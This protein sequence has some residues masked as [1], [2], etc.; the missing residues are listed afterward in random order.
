MTGRENKRDEKRMQEKVESKGKVQK[1][2]RKE[3]IVGR[4]MKKLKKQLLK[5]DWQC[6]YTNS[7]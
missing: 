4:E 6:M 5:R 7:S 3:I 2:R 1:G